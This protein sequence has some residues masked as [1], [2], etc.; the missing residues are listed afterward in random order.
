MCFAQALDAVEHNASDMA[1]QGNLFGRMEDA[2]GDGMEDASENDAKEI[3]GQGIS[4]VWG[5]TEEGRV[6][7]LRNKTEG[8]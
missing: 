8:M 2:K 5:T 7:G 1:T 3:E 6:C 4:G